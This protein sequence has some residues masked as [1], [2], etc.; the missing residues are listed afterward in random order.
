[1]TLRACAELKSNL[2]VGAPGCVLSVRQLV[3]L[4]PPV[5]NRRDTFRWFESAWFDF[6]DVPVVGVRS[7]VDTDYKLE[8]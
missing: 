7:R 5:A 2:G 6:P 8:L 3:L 4:K 1:M